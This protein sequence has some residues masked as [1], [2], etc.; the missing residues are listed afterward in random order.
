LSNQAL[1]NPLI[2]DIAAY[3]VIGIAVVFLILTIRPGHDWGGD[4]ALYIQH[5]I[6]IA[7]GHP[8]SDTWFVYNPRDPLM[9]PRSYPPVYPLSLAPVYGI[10]GLDLYAMKIAGILVFAVFLLLYYRYVCHRLESPVAQIFVVACMAFSPWFWEAKDRI[11][12]DFLFILILYASIVVFDRMYALRQPV[13]HRYLLALGGGLLVSLLYGTRSVGMLIVPALFLHDIIRRRSISRATLIVTIVFAVFYVTQN[14]FLHTD[15]SYFE[16]LKAVDTEEQG[17]VDTTV[18]E[19]AAS[20]GMLAVIK[21]NINALGDRIPRK[22]HTYGSMMSAYWYIGDS[23]IPGA[24]LLSV[25]TVLAIA[26]F[27]GFITRSPSMGDYF[28]L[29]YVMILLVVPFGQQR[30]LLPLVPLYL[31]Y[32]VRATEQLRQLAKNRRAGLYSGFLKATPAIVSVII[33]ASYASSY[34][35]SDSAV[36]ARGVE[37]SESRELFDFIRENTPENSLLVFHKPRPLALFT[38]RHAVKYHWEP[39]LD[40]LWRDLSDMGA[41][42]IVLPKY[43]DTTVHEDYFF[44]NIVERYRQNLQVIFENDNFVVYR[45][46]R[47]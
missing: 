9:S 14:A 30:Y 22:L 36:I 11:L 31:L 33:A 38:G 2:K 3:S 21:S 10:F 5:A 15:Q 46:V 28:I 8:Y 44:P 16:S 1:N 41:T 7:T 18:R 25:M 35:L 23:I 26:G 20:E 12:P 4:F 39:D 37:S 27:I 42:H 47:E 45:I 40:K 29:T 13:L 32:I 6:N 19:G 24:I 34:A 43:L 17:G